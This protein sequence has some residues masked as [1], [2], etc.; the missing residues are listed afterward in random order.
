M[1]VFLKGS[2]FNGNCFK[3][4]VVTLTIVNNSPSL[5]IVNKD[6][7]LTIVNKERSRKETNLKGIGTYP[8]NETIVFENDIKT[9]QKTIV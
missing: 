1:V 9:N 7:L 4:T 8:K 5:T 3:K 2:F 6:S